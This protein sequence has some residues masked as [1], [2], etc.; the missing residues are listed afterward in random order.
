MGDNGGEVVVGDRREDEREASESGIEQLGRAKWLSRLTSAPRYA[1]SHEVWPMIQ[2]SGIKQR[3]CS[4][5]LARGLVVL[6][7]TMGV[8]LSTA[9]LPAVA[10]A[11]GSPAIESLS[12][13]QVT[14]SNATLEAQI[15]PG[16]LETTYELRMG[17]PCAPPNECIRN[18]LLAKANIPA[19]APDESVSVELANASEQPNIEPNTEYEY[20]IVAKNS[21]GTVEKREV[22][23]TQ[24]ENAALAPSQVETEPAELTADGFKLKG[25]LNPEHSPTTYYFV[26]KKAGEAECEDLEGCGTRTAEGGPV[27]GDAQQEVPAVEVTGLVPGQAYIYWLIARNANGTVR[28]EELTL[29]AP[30]ELAPSEV[31]TEPSLPSG[32]GGFLASELPGA[33]PAL[34]TAHASGLPAVDKPK[35]KVLTHAQKLAKALNACDKKPK[36]QRVGCEKQAEKKYATIKKKKS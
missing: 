4:G 24:P 18:L 5:W 31:K 7:A 3:C 34:A 2:H 21:A 10:L 27:T 35:A 16:G 23:K 9:A 20:L 28:G 8:A 13:S 32:G 15:N 1:I 30:I 14:Q 11:A 19:T 12:A 25:K 17:D 36:R 26:Y 33:F 29:T 6:R 22:F